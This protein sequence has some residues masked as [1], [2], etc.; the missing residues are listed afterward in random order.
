MFIKVSEAEFP[1]KK[2]FFPLTTKNAIQLIIILGIVIFSNALFNNFA[3]DDYPFIIN[4]PEVHSINISQTFGPNH[5]FN[6][7]SFYRPIP[8]LYFSILLSLFTTN[9]FFYHF[10]QIALHVLNTCLLYL[11]FQNFFRRSS[12][13]LFLSLVFLGHPIQVE[14]VSF[15]AASGNPLFFLFGMLALILSFQDT[16]S[17][18]RLLLISI[19]L[20]LSLLTKEVGLLFIGLI[21][22]YRLLFKRNK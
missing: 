20:T 4:N 11:V 2:Y 3:W 7:G 16:I 19:L 8:A 14:S 22:F 18:K 15:I 5:H 6:A 1:L 21:I 13:S 9:A 12:V 17:Y 10:A